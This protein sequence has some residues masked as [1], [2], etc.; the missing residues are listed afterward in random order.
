MC[1]PTQATHGRSSGATSPVLDGQMFGIYGKLTRQLGA[2][3]GFR[4][5][6]SPSH[7]VSYS[8]H[9]C[10]SATSTIPF[11]A[12]VSSGLLCA[13]SPKPQHNTIAVS[14]C[15]ISRYEDCTDAAIIP[16]RMLF[17]LSFRWHMQKLHGACGASSVA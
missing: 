8:L 5:T 14:W 10:T 4:R 7:V 11:P 15:N 12:P 17:L 2:L 9:S 16:V 1:T 3:Q 6:L 13:G